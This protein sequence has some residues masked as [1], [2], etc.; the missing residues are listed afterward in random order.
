MTSVDMV[1]ARGHPVG[2][3]EPETAATEPG[4]T[5][6]LSGRKHV[7]GAA[8]TWVWVVTALAI[9]VGAAM[10][11]WYL[12]HRPTTSDDAIAGLMPIKFC[13]GTFPLSFGARATVGWSPT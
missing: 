6:R 3:E 2:E 13:T 1:G 9:L 5:P 11:G 12:F 10:R 4:A 7:A 8:A